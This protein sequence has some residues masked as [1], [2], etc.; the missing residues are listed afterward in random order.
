LLEEVGKLQI[1][2]KSV[3]K[4]GL[5]RLKRVSSGHIGLRY[6]FE[7]DPWRSLPDIS[8]DFRQ[9]SHLPNVWS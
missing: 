6:G 3:S 5:Y 4:V 8:H 9:E 1:C 7:L 2:E